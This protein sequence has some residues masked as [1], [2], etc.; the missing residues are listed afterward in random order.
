[1]ALVA[2]W[3]MG[4]S[5]DVVRGVRFVCG[6]GV[7]MWVLLFAMTFRVGCILSFEQKCLLL[8]SVG[9]VGGW[10]VC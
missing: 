2:L 9:V 4:A 3:R 5:F 10:S 6:C 7:R 8:G 1:M